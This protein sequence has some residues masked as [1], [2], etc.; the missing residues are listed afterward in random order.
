MAV[1]VALAKGCSAAEDVAIET[2]HIGW[3]IHY[4]LLEIADSDIYHLKS[5]LIDLRISNVIS[6][7]HCYQPLLHT[8]RQLPHITGQI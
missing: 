2:D 1:L 4:K 6:T 5:V 3:Y 7:A 8:F